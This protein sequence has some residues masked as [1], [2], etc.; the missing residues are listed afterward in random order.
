MCVERI[1][2]RDVD[3]AR[4]DE[5]AFQAAERMHQRTVGALVVVDSAEVPI[6]I[7]TD[8]DLTVRVIAAGRDGYT[9]SVGQV[10]TPAPKTVSE[11][12]SLESVLLL[13]QEFA[14]RRLPVINDRGQLVGIITLDDILIL[15]SEGMSLVGSVLKQETPRAAAV[16]ASKR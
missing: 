2:Q 1:C 13:M 8:R 9:T 4:S 3:T 10:M 6:G 16:L 5:N 15:L 12:A 11:A 14:F 7:V